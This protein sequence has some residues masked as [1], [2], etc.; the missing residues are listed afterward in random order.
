MAEVSGISGASST[1]YAA[2]ARE[3]REANNASKANETQK[4]N[5]ANQTSKTAESE[6][7]KQPNDKV[8]ITGDDSDENDRDT[9]TL[10][11][12]LAANY[13]GDEE[14]GQESSKLSDT[15]EVQMAKEGKKDAGF[16]KYGSKGA[17]K[18][19]DN[20]AHNKANKF[21]ESLTDAQKESG[22]YDFDAMVNN[23]KSNLKFDEMTSSAK[24]FGEIASA[25]G[26]ISSGAGLVDSIQEGDGR[27][28]LKNGSGLAKNSLETMKTVGN[29][30]DDIAKVAGKYGDDA[31][32][33]FLKGAGE[34]GEKALKAVPF[35]GTAVAGISG[36]DTAIDRIEANA[37]ADGKEASTAEKIE[38][39]ITGATAGVLTDLA[40][41]AIAGGIGA[42][43]GTA[44]CP[45]V[46]TA[47]G[48]IA[49]SLIGSFAGDFLANK[50]ADA[51]YEANKQ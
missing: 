40:G 16:M 37:K 50:G 33:G 49:G 47:I 4:T 29:H 14:E 11:S 20:I 36:A 5:S 18:A 34:V 31:L 17:A 45:G 44:I 26:V 22:H 1:D 32:K 15:S 21:F 42:A 13:G 48:F 24:G 41:D 46:G 9:N 3:R 12:A 43:I 38:A 23:Q 6:G 27:D 7:V 2:E 28:I 35:L 10:T 8:A 19:A 25:A 39:G 51:I 30:A